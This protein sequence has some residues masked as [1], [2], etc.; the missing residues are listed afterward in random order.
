MP[1]DAGKKRYIRKFLQQIQP[2][3]GYVENIWVERDVRLP[4]KE[5]EDDTTTTAESLSGNS[6]ISNITEL[7]RD[8][9]KHTFDDRF[10]TF[11]FVAAFLGSG[12][13]SLLTYLHELTTT[14]SNYEKHSV[15]IQ[16]PLSHLRTVGSSHNFSIKLYCYILGDTFWQLIHNQN[17]LPDVKE[18]AKNIL[19]EFDAG[20]LLNTG[21]R[22]EIKLNPFRSKFSKF[23]ATSEVNFVELFFDVI[24]QVTKVDPRFTFVYLTD[25]LDSLE[26][27]PEEIEETRLIFR[28][29]LKQAVQKFRASIPLLIYLVGTSDNVSSLIQED[30]VLKSLV[31]DSV[32]NL[33]SGSNKEFMMIKQEIDDR[34]KGAYK[35]YKN[36]NSAWQEIENI[37]W[38]TPTNFRDFCQYYSGKV[39]EIHERYFAEA[40]EQKFEGDA[41]GLVEAKCREKWGKYLNKKVY[42]LSTVETTKVIPGKKTGEKHALDCYVELL[43]NGTQVARGFGEA[44]NY[45]LLSSHLE[46]FSKWLDDFEFNPYLSDNNPPELAFMIAPSCSSL[47]EKKLE[48][49]NIEFIQADKVIDKK[50]TTS[51]SSKNSTV[52][53]IIEIKSTSSSDSKSSTAVNINT[54]N[55]AELIITFRGT[56]VKKK[57]IQK[58]LN[59]RNSNHYK[60]L[61]HLVSDLKFS[62]NVKA[63]LQ[64][65]LDHEEISFSD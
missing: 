47:L 41:R 58:L 20:S 23:F 48:L 16:F 8:D 6:S 39:L 45:E 37:P 10:F 54:A 46:I 15:V 57:T 9:L 19:E 17:L 51:P 32:I 31:K 13:T 35:G 2:G 29:L 62:D 50:S 44:K 30:S 65:K 27:F 64:V 40:E 42:T 7:L 55:E 24:S 61:N 12:K 18:V 36:F 5:G 59:N 49:Q 43:H 34:I 63:K 26:K 38:K 52:D 14:Q 60:D 21:T 25:E 11:R 53:K 1:E 33:S 56:N 4:G 22:E 3:E 28:A